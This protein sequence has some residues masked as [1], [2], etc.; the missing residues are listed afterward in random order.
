MRRLRSIDNFRAITMIM[1]IWI[2]LRVWWLRDIDQ[3]FVL[4]TLP[5]T[6]RVFACAFL[7]IAGA[8]STLFIKTRINNVNKTKTYNLRA[9][10]KE[11]FLRAFFIFIVAISYNS[12]VA[13]M[14]MNPLII[15]KWFLLLTT[16]VSLML[17]WPFM[18]FSKLSRIFFAIIL[19]VMNY[20][21]FSFLSGYEGQINT[22]GFLYYFLYHSLDQDPI[23]F[24][25]SFFLLGSVIGDIILDINTIDKKKERRVTLKNKL[26]YPSVIIGIF[27]MIFGL[28]FEYPNYTNNQNF[29]WIAFPLGFNLVL[30]A[31][32]IVIEEYR[33]VKINTRFRFFNYFSYYSLTIFFSHN[34]LYFLFYSLLDLV[35]IWLIIP[36]SIFLFGV[37]MHFIFNS[38]WKEY[39]SVKLLLGKIIKEL[40]A[41]NGIKSKKEIP[42]ITQ[43]ILTDKI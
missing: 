22:F 35:N 12:I 28:I 15:W 10:K 20:Y 16:S 8:S 25:F 7:I 6:D 4:L 24:T 17:M 2:H 5:F 43:I 21:I 13:L 40:V 33:I 11:Y 37:V 3:W 36:I 41:K 31:L 14:F 19:W 27:L 39:L 29:S 26:L 30:L 18:K 34:I 42:K 32:L 9:V 1:M 23:F 38:K